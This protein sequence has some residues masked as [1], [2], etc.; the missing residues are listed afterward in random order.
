M[1]KGGADQDCPPP[2]APTCSEIKNFRMR[3]VLLC[4]LVL[5]TTAA[6]LPTAPDNAAGEMVAS[7]T[8]KT[9]EPIAKPKEAR[10]LFAKA[11]AFFT[12]FSKHE[13]KAKRKGHGMFGAFG[14]APTPS[15]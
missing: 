1:E 15:K 2:R 14:Y 13:K 11:R 8:K 5:A 6:A 4:V 10:G 9:S 12:S 3:S 7:A